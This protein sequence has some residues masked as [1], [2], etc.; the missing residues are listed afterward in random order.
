MAAP[1]GVDL[2]QRRFPL[3]PLGV[4][5]GHR[6]DQAGAVERE[7]QPREPR[8]RHK[9]GEIGERMGLIGGRVGHA[10]DATEPSSSDDTP[11]RTDAVDRWAA[12][13]SVAQA[14]IDS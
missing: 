9:V 13:E 3:R 4:Q 5:R 10:L 2:P 14:R 1:S 12:C 11:G 6:S 8:Q 7:R